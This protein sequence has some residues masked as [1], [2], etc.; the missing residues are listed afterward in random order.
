MRA[1]VPITVLDI[2]WPDLPES[3]SVLSTTR[4]GGVSAA[5]YDDG[6]GG[7]GLN[8]GTHVG[9]TAD[10]VMRNRR[11]LR[12]QLPSEPVWLT[13]VHGTRVIN[14]D[15][16]PPSTEADASIATLT[17]VVCTIMTADCTPVLLADRRGRVVGA[18][19]AGWRGL[20]SGV[21]EATVNAMRDKGAEEILAWLGPGIGPQAFEVG[22]DVVDAFAHLQADR[23]VFKAID[24]KPGKFLA[25]LPELARRAL[26]GVGVSQV[27][28]G[29]HCTVSD[30]HRF[31]SFRRDR[32]T[33]RMASMIWIN[34]GSD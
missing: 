34:G 17:G 7:G 19:H 31:F 33:G 11:L 13:Q 6:T 24:H 12:Q 2:P 8:L 10:S 14:A 30:P 23:V 5:P 15:S 21:L 28:G 20:A 1:P 22:H 16:V 4:R 9:D 29:E 18:A 26:A 3:V 32:T 25:D 27:T